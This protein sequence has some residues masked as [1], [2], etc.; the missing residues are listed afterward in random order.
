MPTSRVLH[1]L[2]LCMTSAICLKTYFPLGVESNRPTCRAD[3]QKETSQLLIEKEGTSLRYCTGKR[4]GS[5]IAHL[6]GCLN[7]YLKIVVLHFSSQMEAREPIG[8]RVHFPACSALTMTG[9]RCTDACHLNYHGP[10]LFFYSN[11]NRGPTGC[12]TTKMASPGRVLP[13]SEQQLVLT[14]VS[15]SIFRK[16]FA[17]A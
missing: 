14:E 13:V 11:V 8:I 16:V 12:T 3:R 17:T 1:S 7:N 9:L 4:V 6:A 10:G 2:P 15:S 5:F